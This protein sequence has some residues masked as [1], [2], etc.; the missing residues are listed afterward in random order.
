MKNDALPEIPP[1]EGKL[2]INYKFM[3]GRL[4]PFILVRLVNVQNYTSSAFYEPHTP[5]FC[6]FDFS[7]TYNPVK[8]VNLLAGVD[9]LF[10]KAYYEHLNRKIIGRTEN[11]YEPGRVFFIKSL[12]FIL[13]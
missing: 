4:I 9:N 3:S 6:L 8:Y 10:D 5:G 1:L 11:L 13:S 7:I 2:N 12:F